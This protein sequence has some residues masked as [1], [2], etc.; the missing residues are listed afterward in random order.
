MTETRVMTEDLRAAIERSGYYPGLVTDAVS[1]ALGSEPVTAFFVHHDAIFDPGMEVRRHMTVLA[2]TPTR[3]VY[4]HTDEHPADDEPQSRPR[5]ETSSEAVRFSRVTSVSLTRVVPDPATYV[6]GVTMPSE[7]ILTIGWN[8]LSHV[9]LEPAHCGDESCEADHGYLGTITADDLTLRISEAADGEDA[10]RQVLKFASALNDRLRRELMAMA[11]EPRTSPIVP[12]YG[13]SS[14]ADLSASILASLT[15]DDSANVLGLPE[16]GRVCLLVIDG[17]GLE[18]LRANQAA[19]P[20]LAELAFN[21]RPLTAGFPSTTVTSLASLGTGLAPAVHGMLGYQVAIPG[22]DRLLNGLRWPRDIDPAGWQPRPTIFD[23]AVAAG[24]ASVHVAPSAYE[25]SGL[26]RA[27]LRGAQYRGADTLG[28]LA[29]LAGAALAESDRSLV[30]VYHG[31]LDLAGHRYGVSSPAWAFQLAHVDRLA[32]QLASALPYGAVLYVTAD[33]GMVDVGPDDR[34][35]ADGAAAA[36]RDGVALLGGEARARHVYARQGA[37]A[38]VL[39]TWREVLGEHAWV[40][41]RVEAIKEG[42]FGPPGAL[43][44]ADEA[45]AARIGDV[46]AACAG[47]SAIVASAAEPLETSLIG[48]HG[49]LTAAEQLIPM[50]AFSARLTPGARSSPGSADRGRSLAGSWRVRYPRPSA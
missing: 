21:S 46:V 41:S 42:W 33:H 5:A 29:A 1:S 3:L 4:S 43:G 35:D 19:A 10:V 6:P 9:E 18:L 25:D 40:M 20:F 16:A 14:L 23:R 50:L 17:L 38:D 44:G 27:A 39:A 2:L 28:I 36:L 22:T 49:S 8:V 12:S 11:R 45:M 37:A 34:I 13:E 26:T 48:M 32:E 15:G 24:V 30:A 31:D 7:V 47:T